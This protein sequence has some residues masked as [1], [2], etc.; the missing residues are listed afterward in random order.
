MVDASRNDEIRHAVNGIDT[1][2]NLLFIVHIEVEDEAIRL[3]PARRATR[4]ELTE[5]EA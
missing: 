4:R 3:I 5:Y 2:W 1:R